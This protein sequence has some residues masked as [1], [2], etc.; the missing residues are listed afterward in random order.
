[1]V[2]V[3]E[4]RIASR[5]SIVQ[6]GLEVM[7]SAFF[8]RLLVVCASLTIY[9]SVGAADRLNVLLIAIDDLNDWIGCMGGHPQAL[10]PNMD[11]LAARGI[12]FY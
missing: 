1:M 9:S 7:G 2:A 3:E 5:P 6:L 10:T 8:C 4:R 12:L 11:R